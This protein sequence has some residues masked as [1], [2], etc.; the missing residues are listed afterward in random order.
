MTSVEVC[1]K[2]LLPPNKLNSVFDD[3]MLWHD[4]DLIIWWDSNFVSEFQEDEV[5]EDDDEKE[6]NKQPKI[7]L[8]M[9]DE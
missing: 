1:L 4:D 2:S 9:S 3:Q 5:D 7:G 6:E 8:M